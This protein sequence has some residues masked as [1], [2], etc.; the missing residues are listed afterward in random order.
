MPAQV[1]A[2]IHE[3]VGDAQRGRLRTWGNKRTISWCP[4]IGG[5]VVH[6][7]LHLCFV[8]CHCC[9]HVG[10]SRTKCVAMNYCN[11]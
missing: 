11:G 2:A 6:R 7:K 5:L 1:A 3:T 9:R 10:M 8:A 4:G